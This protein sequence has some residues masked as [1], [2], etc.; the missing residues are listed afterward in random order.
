MYYPYYRGK[1]YE[2]IAIREQA[3]LLAEREFTPIIEPVKEQLNGLIRTLDGLRDVNGRVILVSNPQHGHFSRRNAELME[4]IQRRYGDWEDLIVGVLLSPR[5]DLAEFNDL[6]DQIGNREVGLIHNGFTAGR[7]LVGCIGG[8]PN[9]STSV[10][11]DSS[12]VDLDV[13]YQS[14]FDGQQRKIIVRDG[15]KRRVR[16]SDHPECELFSTLHLTYEIE[17]ATG[18]GDFLIVG[19]DYSETGGPAY[20]V[21]L[22]LTYIDDGNDGKMF[23][24]HFKS[25]R[26]DTPTDPGG[27]FIEAL[28]KLVQHLGSE[29]INL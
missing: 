22:H 27:K 24:R 23:I 16:N 8:K 1:Q 7:E 18:F 4:L 29:L 25:D 2:L 10:F 13:L 14:L 6:L 15:Y 12:H 28:A 11:V 9:I 26:Q 5:T 19:D 21:A 20:T 17:R 3:Q